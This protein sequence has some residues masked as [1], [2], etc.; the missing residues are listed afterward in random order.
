MEYCGK[1][2]NGDFI[3]KQGLRTVS[4]ALSLVLIIVTAG[5][6]PKVEFVEVNPTYEAGFTNHAFRGKVLAD[7]SLNMG[8]G[9]IKEILL[10]EVN[11][12][13]LLRAEEKR[14][15]LESQSESNVQGVSAGEA[16]QSIAAGT[17]NT[18]VWEI[19]DITAVPPASSQSDIPGGSALPP[20]PGIPTMPPPPIT[21]SIPEG[22][23][24]P[25]TP[26]KP[27]NPAKPVT[28]GKPGTSEKPEQP[29]K[30]TDT[31]NPGNSG[32][33]GT[34]NENENGGTGGN[35]GEKEEPVV[36]QPE[37]FLVNEEGMIY[38]YNS[39]AGL[40]DEDGVLTLPSEGCSGILAGT[41]SSAGADIME[42]HIPENIIY[43]EAG[44]T[45]E[46]TSLFAI[47]VSENNPVY[48]SS[49]GLLLDKSMTTALAF[50]SA[51]V[52]N[53][54]M[55][56]S[57]TKLAELSFADSKIMIL[58]MRGC[59]MV[60]IAE[61]AFEGCTLQ[62]FAPNEYREQYQERFLD[63]SITVR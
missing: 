32:G 3:R 49:D 39:E 24:K 12:L 59:G 28:P 33:S 18:E 57:V 21:P 30:P 51:R 7:A 1:I 43:I 15:V 54:Q 42:L 23:T 26:S 38:S 40:V 13:M 36:V 45:K 53:H 46:L 20:Q 19:Q 56:H 27:E 34:T 22:P 6:L 35:T 29:E 61:N 52:G 58:D 44:T 2:A 50:P 47:E 5:R 63:S 31:G 17:V 4:V 14:P 8:T 60:E 11:A 10:K 62:I 16:A 9:D 41:F 55:P 48:T 25:E 37:G